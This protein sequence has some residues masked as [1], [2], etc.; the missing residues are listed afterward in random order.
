MKMMKYSLLMMVL[1]FCFSISSTS[2]SSSSSS[3]AVEQVAPCCSAAVALTTVVKTT[4][5]DV[6][7]SLAAMQAYQTLGC[8]TPVGATGFGSTPFYG[9]SP[10]PHSSLPAAF[11]AD[12]MLT[13]SIF[14][15][16]S[17]ED[18]LILRTVCTVLC[19]SVSLSVCLSACLSSKIRQNSVKLD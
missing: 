2:S 15:T 8:Q 6:S 13:Q 5:S 1:P 3:S 9:Q 14:V 12:G 4:T 16:L 7:W 18:P 19:L 10:S 11:Y 17:L